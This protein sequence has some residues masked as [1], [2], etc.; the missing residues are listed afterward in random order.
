MKFR[1]HNETSFFSKMVLL[2]ALLLLGMPERKK[3]LELLVNNLIGKEHSK[4]GQIPIS[5]LS[6]HSRFQ[7]SFNR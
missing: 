3:S 5:H 6:G 4:M 2:F 1:I 7:S